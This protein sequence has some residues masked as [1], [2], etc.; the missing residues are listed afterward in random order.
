MIKCQENIAKI[1]A[2]LTVG[3]EEFIKLF[4]TKR[5]IHVSN[6]DQAFDKVVKQ[7]KNFMQYNVMNFF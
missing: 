7:F 2:N 6:M 5:I 1:T 4:G 3:N